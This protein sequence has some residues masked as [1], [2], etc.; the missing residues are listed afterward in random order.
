MKKNLLRVVLTIFSF[1]L[2][3]VALFFLIP[4]S[5]KNDFKAYPEKG[6]C[7]F[8]LKTCE[9]LFGCKEYNNIQVPCGSVSTLCGEKMLCDCSDSLNNEIVEPENNRETNNLPDSFKADYISFSNYGSNIFKIEDYRMP[10]LSIVNGEIDCQE[11]IP[12]PSVVALTSS[13]ITS[14]K[15][16]N[17]KKYCVMYSIEGAA[18]SVFT[19]NAYTTVIDD[20]VYLINFVARYNNC[21]NYPEDELLKCATEREKFNLDLLVDEEIEKMKINN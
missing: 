12:N 21:G 5:C 17:G 4:N 2:V 14:K 19:Q 20:N 16:I 15:E 3:F 18:G 1:L 13:V 7:E 9:G 11:T 8:N 6:Y 10:G